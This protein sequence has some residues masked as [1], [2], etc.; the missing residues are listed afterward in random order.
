M[1]GVLILVT[2]FVNM[3]L[4]AFDTL[5]LAVRSFALLG[6]LGNGPGC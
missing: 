5:G 4:G 6:S 3:C 2:C 1:L